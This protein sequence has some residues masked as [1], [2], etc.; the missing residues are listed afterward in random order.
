M[1]VASRFNDRAYNRFDMQLAYRMDQAREVGR[2]YGQPPK[3]FTKMEREFLTDTLRQGGDS[4]LF[5]LGSISNAAVRA[6][7]EPAD[8]MKEFSKDAP[9]VAVIGQ[10]VVAGA[11]PRILDTAAKALSWRIK[12]GEKFVSTID[13]AQA[14][15]NLDEYA[16]V[17]SATPTK[18][19]AVRAT[20][21]L[22][23]EYEARRQ[24]KEA[25]DQGLY[26]TVVRRLMGETTDRNGKTYGGVG[27]Q[28]TGWSDGKIRSG[29]WFGSTPKVMVPAGVRTDS[30]DDMVSAIRMK[31][32]AGAPPLDGNGR[33]I[34][35]SAIRRATWISVGPGL[36]GLKM[37]A[38]EF[39]K[40]QMARN[41]DG[42]D[43]ALDIRRLLPALK[44]R[45]P[46]IFEGYDGS[47]RPEI[48]PDAVSAT[49]PVEDGPS[50]YERRTRKANEAT[51]AIKEWIGSTPSPRE[52]GRR[53]RDDLRE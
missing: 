40:S 52:L 8:V 43:Y 19:D 35:I 11:D 13:K 50:W 26:S 17:L 44:R 10:A 21:N 51:S 14:K 49:P 48:E 42:S 20:A 46:E 9:E 4:M 1:S 28:G 16:D 27:D 39:G 32:L 6:G 2:Y 5:V 24:G 41:P 30:F 37:G 12:Q 3:V 53:I 15:P 36:Y 31:D 29:G 33:P 38:N 25:F 23:Y 45:K 34:P 22:V 7:I 18:V 47:Q